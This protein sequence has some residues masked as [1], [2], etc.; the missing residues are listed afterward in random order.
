MS[1]VQGREPA[2]VNSKNFFMLT[3][4]KPAGREINV[5][6]TGSIRLKKTAFNPYLSNQF[7]AISICDF[8][9]KK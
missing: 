6:T 2:K 9:I 5:L 8:F 4:A 1:A 7:W 3:W